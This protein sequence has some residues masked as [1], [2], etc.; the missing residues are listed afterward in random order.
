MKNYVVLILFCAISILLAPFAVKD[1]E[2]AAKNEAVNVTAVK[3]P[4]TQNSEEPQQTIA[5]FRS[6]DNATQEISLFEY[7]CG[8]VAAEM[9]LAY[10]EEALKAQAVACYTNALRLMENGKDYSNA[11]ISDDTA[12]HQGYIDEVQ[13]KEKWGKDFDKY[14]EK[15]KKVVKAVENQALYYDDKL[16]V[17]AFFA[18]SNGKTE[19][20]ENLWG[21]NVDYLTSVDSSGDKLSPG[22]AS[23]ISFSK[24]SLIECME[25]ESISVESIKN[26]KNIV[27]IT[28]KTHT[29]TV[30]KAELNGKSY[31][32]EDIRKI[33]S[34][35]SPTFTVKTTENAV[36]FSVYGYGHGIGMSQYGADYLAEKGYTYKEILLHYYQGAE[37]K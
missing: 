16:C 31:T 36:T 32:G 19:N 23:T 28:E 26:L 25:K 15:L 14:E 18:I 8:S 13:R 27:K 29:G 3:N 17:A 2:A 4:T 6:C 5:V 21:S 37:I 34:L 20:A 24:D 7:V 10:N 35:R 22:Y 1:S 30:L 11:H 12:V 9:P 33:F